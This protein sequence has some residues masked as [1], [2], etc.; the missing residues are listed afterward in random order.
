MRTLCAQM[1]GFAV[2]VAALFALPQ[3]AQAHAGHAHAMHVQAQT[4]AHAADLSIVA[5]L[6]GK[7]QAEQSLTS[8]MRSAPGHDDNAPCD[9][10]CCAQ[11]SC[12]A[13]FSL[14]APMPPLV[15]PPALSRVIASTANRL[16]PGIGAAAL[17][18]PP[19]TFA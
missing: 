13:C 12:A 3:A 19:K 1:F 11:I 4:H 17:R 14:M 5:D 9:R 15:A 2:L 7:P 18:R 16:P 10:G 6:A 8:A